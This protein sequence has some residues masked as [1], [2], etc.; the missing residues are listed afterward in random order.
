MLSTKVKTYFKIT[1]WISRIFA[2]ARKL[3]WCLASKIT[4]Y[5]LRCPLNRSTVT[6]V[7]PGS[8]YTLVY[9]E[10]C[11]L[12]SAAT[13]TLP[14]RES[15][16]PAAWPRVGEKTGSNT[17]CRKLQFSR[18]LSAWQKK[19][20]MWK[21]EMS[22]WLHTAPRSHRQHGHKGRQTLVVSFTIICF[23]TKRLD[24]GWAADP[25]YMWWQAEQSL[26]LLGIISVIQNITNTWLNKLHWNTSSIPN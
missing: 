2:Q 18:D 20:K 3:S 11:N 24:T 5:K 12:G 26:S 15:R 23:I 25:I 14:M 21:Q 1:G 9:E 22:L 19:R 6:D 13:F 10:S 4:R 7:S 8:W 17:N 16:S